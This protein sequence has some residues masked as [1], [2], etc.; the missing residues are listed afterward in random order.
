MVPQMFSPW[1][2][3][4]AVK[5]ILPSIAERALVTIAQGIFFNLYLVA[6]ILFPKTCHRFVG[7]LEEEAVISYTTFLQEIDKGTRLRPSD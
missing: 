6:Y 7:Y 3:E 2:L 5:I 4:M 1:F